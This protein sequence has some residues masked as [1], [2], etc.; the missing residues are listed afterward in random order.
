MRSYT[1]Q[2][3]ISVDDF[4]IPQ[5]PM[6]ARQGVRHDVSQENS[7]KLSNGLF[8]PP[9][10][11]FLPPV[12][13]PSPPLSKMQI[14]PP[15]PQDELEFKSLDEN[16]VPAQEDPPPNSEQEQIEPSTV[17]RGSVSSA[18]GG[19]ESPVTTTEVI[20]LD[21]SI[22]GSVPSLKSQTP[23]N[24]ILSREESAETV[25]M[26]Q[27][28]PQGIYTTGSII[29]LRLDVEDPLQNSISVAPTRQ[30]RH[31]KRGTLVHKNSGRT[32]RGA[33]VRD[34]SRSQPNTALFPDTLRPDADE[35]ASPLLHRTADT[36]R[37]LRADSNAALDKMIEVLSPPKAVSVIVGKGI[38][39]QNAIV[40]TASARLLVNLVTRVGVEKV[41]TH[42]G[43]M[44]DK[45]LVTGSNLLTEGSLDTRCFAKQL[46]RLLSTYPTFNS[47]MAEVVPSHILRN[48]SK[49]LQSLR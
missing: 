48:I 6:L 14:S 24:D 43:D 45:I 22:R 23:T 29:D 46:F 18:H 47:T 13:P 16:D 30:T 33:Q 44:R 35:L 49:T 7:S 26:E 20:E 17:S 36:N 12:D 21:S 11:P 32:L 15:P 42:P 34:N 25:A 8:T 40:R 41:M 39:H 2:G 27:R 31:P 38:S 4:T 9:A 28:T 1:A 5:K 10:E 37:F 19:I 3:E